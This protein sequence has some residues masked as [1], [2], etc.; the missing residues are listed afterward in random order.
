M[1][2][3]QLHCFYFLLF[4]TVFNNVFLCIFVA[5]LSLYN[6]NTLWSICAVCSSSPHDH[7]KFLSSSHCRARE[8]A[9]HTWLVC[10]RE[11]FHTWLVR[12]RGR[13]T[14][15]CARGCVYIAR[16]VARSI[17]IFISSRRRRRFALF[18]GTQILAICNQWRSS[19]YF[20]LFAPHHS[21]YTN[22]C[23]TS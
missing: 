13:L 16:Y 17:H 9:S 22:V 3:L 12:M 15:A 7:V 5:M 10:T 18:N 2:L 6:N 20:L 11:R 14:S 19:F 23:V 21:T 4:F 1:L 8:K